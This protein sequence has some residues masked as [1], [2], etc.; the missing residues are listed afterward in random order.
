MLE[1]LDKCRCIHSESE[2]ISKFAKEMSRN[3]VDDKQIIKN[4]IN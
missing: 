3:A 4:I 2:E 1:D